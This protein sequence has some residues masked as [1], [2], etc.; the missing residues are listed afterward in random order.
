MSVTDSDQTNMEDQFPEVQV[1][2]EEG[3]E[4]GEMKGEKTED[5]GETIEMLKGPDI[6]LL[7]L[8]PILPVLLQVLPSLLPVAVL[9]GLRV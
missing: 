4:E 9:L 8:R 7:G 5:Q 6:I 3:E 1:L 2:Q